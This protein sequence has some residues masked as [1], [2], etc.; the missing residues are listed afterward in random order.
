MTDS[1]LGGLIARRIALTG[2][3]SLADFMAEALGHPRLGYYRHAT[4]VGAAGD[5]TTAPE[6][7]QMF[8]ELLGAWLAERW[9]AMGKPAPVRL[10]ELGP[11]RGALMADALRATRGVPGFHAALDLHLVETNE[12]M[13]AAQHNALR[14]FAPG[15]APTWHE[16]FDTVPEGPLLL[17]ANE[18]F[19]ALPVR[20][21]H[22]TPRG[23]VERMV[24]IDENGALR[25]ALAPGLS[26]FARLLP[27]AA[28][29]AEA[30]ICEAGQALAAAIGDRIARHGGW[31]LIVDYSGEMAGR[32]ASL[33]AVRSHRGADILDR[34]GETDLSAHVDFAAL[35]KASGVASF[36]PVGQGAFLRELGI[37]E[38]GEALKR[39]ATAVQAHAIDAASVRLIAPD[40]MGT[41]FR[42]LALGDGKSAPPVGF[43]D[44]P[45]SSDIPSD[46]T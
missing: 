18:F 36:G 31:A 8:G 2:P 22:R 45:P 39:K 10:V 26:P 19:D 43:S 1:E 28:V 5:F 4:P 35:A 40:Q 29:D 30:E 37:A 7:S 33:Q 6:I 24:G 3:I 9:L 11:G 20:Q 27:E 34:P 16:R 44:I 14:G 13:R 41:L 38:R 42:V 25:L 12:P 17:V 21:F 32:A 46:A 23:W 15:I